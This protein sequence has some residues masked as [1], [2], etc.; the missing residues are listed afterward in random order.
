MGQQL[1]KIL[2]WSFVP[3]VSINERIFL[4]VVIIEQLYFGKLYHLI[5]GIV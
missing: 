2:L 4:E 5:T 1:V 3:T